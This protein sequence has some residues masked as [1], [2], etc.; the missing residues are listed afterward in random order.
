[1]YR[2]RSRRLMLHLAIVISILLL[3]ACG[4]EAAEPTS[5]AQAAAETPTAATTDATPSGPPTGSPAGDETAEEETAEQGEPY[6]IGAVLSI[7]GGAATLGAPER[8]ALQLLQD[9]V[10]EQGGILGPDGLRHPV[11]VIIYDDQSDESQ[12]VLAV[13]RLIESDQVP[14]IIC[15]SQSGTSLAAVDV[16]TRNEV[17]MISLAS[18][19]T[20]TQ[21][22]EERYWAFKPA[23]DNLQVSERLMLYFQREGI[24]RIGL[25]S[26]S[27]EYGDSGRNALHELADDYGVSI[28]VDERFNPGTTDVTTHLN[29]VRTSDAEAVVVYALVPESVVAMKNYRDLGMDI[30]IVFTNSVAT[31]AFI[32]AAGPLAEGAIVPAGKIIVYDTLPDSDHQKE[33]LEQFAVEYQERYGE[34][35]NTFAGHAWDAFW[36][37]VRAFEKHGPDPAAIRDEIEQTSDFVGITGVLTFSPE[38]HTG[39]QTEDMVMVVVQDGR[40]VALAEE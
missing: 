6:R 1:M 38:R 4:G 28:V 9:Q 8:D 13:T 15:C 2:N 40:F 36:L 22:V 7:T 14:A 24:T 33:V 16:V 37:Y 27:T 26:V 5:P 31:P 12:A 20:I 19:E 10:N 25:L 39:F 34:P 32:E 18:S 35:P 30:P 11:E 23:W 3:V 29:R 17:P 21:P